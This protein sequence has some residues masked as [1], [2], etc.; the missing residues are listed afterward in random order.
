MGV[1]SSYSCVGRSGTFLTRI[2]SL[3][4]TYTACNL[5]YVL[6]HTI[7]VHTMYTLPREEPGNQSFRISRTAP[8]QAPPG[9][10]I[11]RIRSKVPTTL[12][13]AQ[14]LQEARD[15]SAPGKAT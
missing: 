15:T 10:R 3:T 8:F 1:A 2:R 14:G 6:W 12:T 5:L 4:H 7:Y 9:S 13:W 11:K